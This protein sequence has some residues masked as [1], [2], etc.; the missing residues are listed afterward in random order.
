MKTI[1]ANQKEIQKEKDFAILMQTGTANEK[2]TAF[3]YLYQRHNKALFFKV[4]RSFKMDKEMG[5][6]LV[7][8]IFMK[9]FQKINSYS[10]DYAFSTWLYKIANNHIIDRKRQQNFEVLNFEL[11]QVSANESSE[12]T[13]ANAMVFQLE[14]KSHNNHELLIRKERAKMVH[15]AI[16]NAIKTDLSKQVLKMVFMEDLAYEDISKKMNISE[17][18]VKTIVFRAKETLRNYLSEKKFDFTYEN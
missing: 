18:K 7:Q 2:Q 9:V 15:Q 4:I 6:D 13:G 3:N 1:T 16:E 12:D 5:R 11:L 14:D 8:E 10:P 17:G